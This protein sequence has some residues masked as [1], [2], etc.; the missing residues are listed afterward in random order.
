MTYVNPFY[1]TTWLVT[2]MAFLVLTMAYSQTTS[3][4]KDPTLFIIFHCLVSQGSR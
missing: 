3:Q 1:C 4:R 2:G